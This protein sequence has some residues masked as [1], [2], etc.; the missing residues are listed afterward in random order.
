MVPFQG[1]EPVS[2][3]RIGD[4]NVGCWAE[5]TLVVA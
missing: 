1:I 5:S 3:W 4:G 2:D